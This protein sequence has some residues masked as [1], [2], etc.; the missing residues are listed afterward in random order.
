MRRFA[1]GLLGACATATVFIGVNDALLAAGT[2]VVLCVSRNGSVRVPAAGEACR[3]NESPLTL[4]ATGPTGATGETGATGPTGATGATGATGVT[5]ATGSTSGFGGNFSNVNIPD[6][7]VFLGLGILEAGHTGVMAKVVL[8]NFS[9]IGRHF[10]AR[11]RLATRTNNATPVTLDEFSSEVDPGTD[12]TQL[13]MTSAFVSDEDA[14]LG[15][16]I[17]LL[18]RE[19]SPN[20]PDQGD[21]VVTHG[22]IIGVHFN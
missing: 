20:S 10:I 18:C 1:I 9:P 11:C 14:A 3:A 16:N 15:T 12:L 22:T 17:Q 8:H 7:E 19:G 6:S 5:G 21:L 4:G 13:L 2:D